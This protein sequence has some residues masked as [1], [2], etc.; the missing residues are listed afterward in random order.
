MRARWRIIDSLGLAA[1]TQ[2]LGL[3]TGSHYSQCHGNSTCI[4][5]L[6]KTHEKAL[7]NRNW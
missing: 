2:A 6:E 7:I 4:D 1:G 5:V 3:Y